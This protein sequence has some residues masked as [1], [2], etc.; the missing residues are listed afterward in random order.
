MKKRLIVSIALML[1]ACL[2]SSASASSI[3][4]KIW[5]ADLDGNDPALLYGVTASLSLS[6]N[7]WVSGMYLM[8]TY[9][10][11]Y[12][13]GIDYD[14]KDGELVLGYSFQILDIGVGAR[15]SEWTLMDGVGNEMDLAIFGPMVYAG[16]GDSFGSTPLGWYVGGSYMFFDFGDAYDAEGDNTDDTFEHYNIEG[17]LSLFLD[18]VTATVGYRFK[19]YV[20]YNDLSFK[21]VAASLGFGF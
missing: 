2:I 14:T 18:P 19:D 11:V 21:G 7:W 15:Y 17:G 8:G 3:A 12:N 5:Y 16:I 6:E 4:G 20:N 9:E 13:S 10:D 1:T